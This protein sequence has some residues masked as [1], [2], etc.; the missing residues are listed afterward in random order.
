MT[1]RADLLESFVPV[2]GLSSAALFLGL[3]APGI[4]ARA[5]LGL[6][7]RARPSRA[8]SCRLSGAQSDG[9]V[10]GCRLTGRA[11]DHSHG[12]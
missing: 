7:A 5:G 2:R 1:T 8:G 4:P 3:A 10:R 12:T 6:G 9:D 11:A